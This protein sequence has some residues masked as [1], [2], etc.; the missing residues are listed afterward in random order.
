MTANTLRCNEFTDDC[1]D[2]RSVASVSQI[3]ESLL[4]IERAPAPRTKIASGHILVRNWKPSTS[5]IPLP[6][7]SAPIPTPLSA[8]VSALGVL[9][10]SVCL[11]VCVC[12]PVCISLRIRDCKAASLS[13]PFSLS[14]SPSLPPP[15]SPTLRIL[16]CRAA[17]VCLSVCLSL[18][19]SVPHPLSPSESYIAEPL[20]SVCLSV[21]LS[22]HPSPT[23]S[24]SPNPRL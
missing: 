21:C 22:L 19:P 3:P 23:L 15:P 13:L 8:F 12:L 2:L 10:L 20:L 5:F 7:T 16:D 4:S 14:L 6:H 17:S 18:P 1:L 9:Y 24:H 11:S